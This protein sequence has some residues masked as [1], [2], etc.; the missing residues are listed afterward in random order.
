MIPETTLLAVG[1][2]GLLGGGHCAGMCGGIVSALSAGAG[3]RLPL[4]LAYNAGRIASYALA[5]AI[6]G[7]LGGMV[8]YYDVL[9]LQ[10]ALYVLAN[11]MLILLGLYLAG[12]S[13]LVTRLEAPGRRLWRHISPLTTRFLPVDT[14]PRAFAV[15]TLW[16]WLPC[17]LTYSALAIALAS[18]GAANGAALML[19]FGLGTLPNLLLA[20][21]LL[22]RARSWFQDRMVR[23]VSGGL[24]LGFGVAGLANAAQLGDQIRRGVLCLI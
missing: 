6:A 8:L 19:A 14:V 18:G 13:S 12:W 16:G 7:A 21:L 10:L 23:L 22:R 11:L 1:L 9:P 4:H 3:S 17:G 5:G 24:V 15:G 20:G 2:A